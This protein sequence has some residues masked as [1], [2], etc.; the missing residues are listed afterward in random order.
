MVTEPEHRESD[1]SLRGAEPGTG[2]G[3]EPDLGVDSIRSVESPCSITAIIDASCLTE[4]LK[5]GRPSAS[6]SR[7]HSGVLTHVVAAAI[8]PDGVVHDAVHDRI[9]VHSGD[10]TGSDHVQRT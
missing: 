3:D 6:L 9:G 8:N 4:Y 10:T 1:Q 5:F 2:S 7:I